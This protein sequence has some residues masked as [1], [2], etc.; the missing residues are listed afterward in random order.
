M[1]ADDRNLTTVRL[2]EAQVLKVDA[3]GPRKV[4]GLDGGAAVALD[5]AHDDAGRLRAGGRGRRLEVKVL[6]TR[7]LG[8]RLNLVGVVLVDGDPFNL[9][10]HVLRVVAAAT[11]DGGGGKA[12]DVKGDGAVGGALERRGSRRANVVA[13]GLLKLTVR[14][15]VL[16]LGDGAVEGR[17]GENR[18]VFVVFGGGE[19]ARVSVDIVVPQ[20][21]PA[22][23]PAARVEEPAVQE[24]QGIV[25]VPA[26]AALWEKA[27]K[28]K[29]D[30]EVCE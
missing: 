28:K 12:Q 22:A 16:R 14:R 15:V 13:D 9:E 6:E 27:W 4:D 21:A 18:V 7:G 24:G 1:L 23:I 26:S 3:Q 2:G 29:R 25:G 30:E 10:E 5:R 19:A 11:S 20:R 8:S 17:Q